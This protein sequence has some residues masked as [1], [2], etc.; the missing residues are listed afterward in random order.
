MAFWSHPFERGWEE[1]TEDVKNSQEK[2]KQFFDAKLG[3]FLPSKEQISLQTPYET[4]I[5]S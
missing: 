4:N 5:N 1:V 2:V 3:E